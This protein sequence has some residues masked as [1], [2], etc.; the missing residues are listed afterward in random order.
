MI[1]SALNIL[2]SKT[3]ER[4][5]SRK[6]RGQILVY[7]LTNPTPLYSE[8]RDFLGCR[9]YQTVQHH[10]KYLQSLNLVELSGGKRGIL[11]TDLGQSIAEIIQ[12]YSQ[13]STVLEKVSQNVSGVS[14]R[15]RVRKLKSTATDIDDWR[16]NSNRNGLNRKVTKKSSVREPECKVSNTQIIKA[17]R[18]HTSITDMAQSLNISRRALRDRI[19]RLERE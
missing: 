10:V 6:L 5:L 13:P 19:A 3:T 7:L 16:E 18:I 8:I 1:M 15:S 11:L 2:M 17:M 12:A 9:S 14:L 4:S